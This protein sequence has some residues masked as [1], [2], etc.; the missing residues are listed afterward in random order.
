MS[1]QLCL[2]TWTNE[3]DNQYAELA[4]LEKTA[5]WERSAF[6]MAKKSYSCTQDYEE[7]RA[8]PDGCIQN[9]NRRF[10][11]YLND[12]DDAIYGVMAVML[13]DKDG[14]KAHPRKEDA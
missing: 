7:Y 3:R 8:D 11:H 6:N 13:V 1:K 2:I 12:E 4:V 5:D 9:L 14:N 10:Y